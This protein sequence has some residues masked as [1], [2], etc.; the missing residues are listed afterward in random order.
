MPV[1]G[2]AEDVSAGSTYGEDQEEY[3]SQLKN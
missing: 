1:P 2:P 3:S